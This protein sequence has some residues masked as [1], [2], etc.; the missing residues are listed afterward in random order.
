LQVEQ[1]GHARLQRQVGLDERPEVPSPGGDQL[2]ERIVRAV[3]LYQEPVIDL[4]RPADQ[5]E[6]DVV[7][8]RTADLAGG[9]QDRLAIEAFVVEQQA[10]HVEDDR[11]RLPG[12]SHL[13]PTDAPQSGRGPARRSRRPSA[14]R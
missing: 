9:R 4:A 2:L 6:E 13:R 1:L 12:K 14:P 8:H 5:L 7:A 3:V 11:C 10:V